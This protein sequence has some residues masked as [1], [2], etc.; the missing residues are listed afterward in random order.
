MTDGNTM[1]ARMTRLEARLDGLVQRMEA[2]FDHVDERFDRIAEAFEALR[3][4]MDRRFDTADAARV[5]DR[6][7][8][9]DILGNHEGRLR[10]L[11]RASD[12][13]S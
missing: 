3:E 13:P 5:A 7:M 9:Y 1:A 2:R 11:E 4:H 6:Q 12:L 8:F 10:N